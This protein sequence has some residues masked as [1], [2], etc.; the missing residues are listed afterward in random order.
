MK[1]S[2]ASLSDSTMILVAFLPAIGVESLRRFVAGEKLMLARSWHEVESLLRACAASALIL[3]PCADGSMNVQSVIDLMR[4]FPTTPVMAYVSMTGPN[5]KAVFELSRHGLSD[6]VVRSPNEPTRQLSKVLNRA[7][8]HTNV[9]DLLGWMERS[10]AELP[11]LV[12][13]AVVDLFERPHRY[14]T[15]ADIALQGEVST[16]ALYRA[17]L[18]AHLMSPKKLLVVAKLLRGYALMRDSGL[19]V[20]DVAASVG[21]TRPANFS[22]HCVDVF[23]SPP[24]ALRN[25]PS[26]E[27]V[28][29]TLLDWLCKPSPHSQ[30]HS[31]PG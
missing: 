30:Q 1:L 13:Q 22:Q 26:R 23:G 25:E 9:S 8:I 19:V 18:T 7:S 28:V 27:E 21:Y 3:D 24:R 5:L 4:K 15:A 2:N 16:K 11:P 12:A 20:R 10:L 6:A 29:R 31:P 17:F 14:T